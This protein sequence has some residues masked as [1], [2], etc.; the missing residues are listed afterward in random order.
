M[1]L[2]FYVARDNR[3]EKITATEDAASQDELL[4]RL[5]ARGLVV[6][7]ILS[8]AK[9]GA[10]LEKSSV[11]RANRMHGG[12][13]NS[14][15]M[16]FCRQL[17]TLLG[18]GVPI[19]KSLNIILK[20]ISSRKLYDVLVALQKSMEAGLSM[21]E[22]MSKHP[23]VF[24]DLWVNLVDSGEAS[25]NLAAILNRLAGY[26][27]RSAS[28]RAKIISALIYPIILLVAGLGALLFLTVKIIPTFAELFK[29]FNLTLPFLTQ[30]IIVVSD[31]IRKY[32]LMIIGGMAAAFFLLKNYIRTRQGRLNYERFL[33]GL[34]VLGDFFRIMVVERFS[35]EMSTLVESGVPILYSLEITER[36]VGNLTMAEVVRQIKEDVRGGKSLSSP[37]EKSG[38]FEPMAVQMISIGEEIGE[39]ANMFKRVDTFYQEYIDTFLSRIT[40]MFEPIM[41]LFMGVII[42]L[43][44]IGIFLPIFQISQL[45]SAGGG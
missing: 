8:D 42:G 44:V 15:L 22:A 2:F 39:L 23:K 32:L 25:G 14:D 37:M 36:S 18:A 11:R 35:S 10:A 7:N 3:G 38:F 17:A 13:T 5:Q 43:M 31:F 45:G 30:M 34:P 19:L 41:L 21:H 16:V 24:S 20:Q 9:A 12:I 1:A 40:A 4:G 28:F 27:E 29:G 33:F 26:L 6:T